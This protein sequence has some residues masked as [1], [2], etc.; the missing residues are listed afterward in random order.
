MLYLRKLRKEQQI[1]EKRTR[2]T[3]P[4]CGS[5]MEFTKKITPPVEGLGGLIF[6]CPTR[7]REGGCGYVKEILVNFA[8]QGQE[9]FV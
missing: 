5:S 4:R 3:C 7:K 6:R 1:R 2:I 9:L 8:P